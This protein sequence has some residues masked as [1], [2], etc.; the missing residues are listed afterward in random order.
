MNYIVEA[1]E[2]DIHLVKSLRDEYLKTTNLITEK[3][4]YLND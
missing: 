3:T 1:G 4:I 2:F